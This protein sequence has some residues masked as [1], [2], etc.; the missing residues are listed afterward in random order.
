MGGAML[1][2]QSAFLRMLTSNLRARTGDVLE[3]HDRTIITKDRRQQCKSHSKVFPKRKYS[4]HYKPSRV[5]T[6]IGS[7]GKS[8]AMCTTREKNLPKSLVKRICLISLRMG[9]TRLYFHPC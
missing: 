1:F 7:R 4:L 6:W 3:S 8:G 2:V 9:S 5:A